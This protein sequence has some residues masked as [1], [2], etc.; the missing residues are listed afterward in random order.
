MKKRNWILILLIVVCLAA[1]LGYRAMDAMRTDTEAPEIKMDAV[2]P[3]VSVAD[4]QTA[5]LQGITAR[6]KRD[7]DV[8]DLLVVERVTLLDSKGTLMVSYAAFDHAGNVAKAQREA[9]YKD[10]R[11]PRFTMASP[12]VF[13]Y[14]SNFD[15]L[16]IVGA[17]DSIDGD[18]QHR[19][20][21]T[22]L[23]A[24]AINEMGTHEVQ[25]QVSN[26]LGDTV[27]QVFPVE[28]YDHEMYDARLNLKNYLVYM[29]AGTNFAPNSYLETFILGGEEVS[30]ENGLPKDYTL[31]LKGGVQTNTPGT[32]V[33][34][35]RVTYTQ[36]NENNPSL[37]RS[38]TGYSKLI[39]VVEG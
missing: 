7:G 22:P 25:F 30:L 39:V 16:N 29:P 31:K 15:V 18:I 20:R 10:Y 35:Y 19:I 38:W 13:T 17:N 1:F 11:S 9:K 3:E 4:P 32:Y 36:R 21:A 37:D 24:V 8:T 5:L 23:D 12:L 33:V 26:S 2:I 34:E 6:D 28:V 14:G 27:T